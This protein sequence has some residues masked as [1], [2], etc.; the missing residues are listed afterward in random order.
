MDSITILRYHVIENFQELAM[1]EFMLKETNTHQKVRNI[2]DLNEI[3]ANLEEPVFKILLNLNQNLRVGTYNLANF[4]D[5][6]NWN[7]RVKRI[8][9][10]IKESE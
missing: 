4:S 5:H 10:F 2:H 3:L 9:E 7:T 1:Y 8:A 6:K